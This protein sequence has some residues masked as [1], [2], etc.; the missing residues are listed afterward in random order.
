MCSAFA[1]I[2]CGLQAATPVLLPN[3]IYLAL[4]PHS[5]EPTC[6]SS[7]INKPFT[8]CVASGIFFRACGSTYES[9]STSLRMGQKGA[10]GRGETVGSVVCVCVVVWWVVVVVACCDGVGVGSGG[11]G[12][13][14]VRAVRDLVFVL[15]EGVHPR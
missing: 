8:T 15:V 4:W 3:V 6:S 9:A 13:C 14:F 11:R 7:P 5:G 1:L 2:T 12:L 10:E